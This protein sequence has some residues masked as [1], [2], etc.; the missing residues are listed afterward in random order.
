MLSL[1][2]RLPWPAS[3]E[4]CNRW[5]SS[6]L[7][8][9]C[10]DQYATLQHRCPGCA[11]PMAPGLSLCVRCREGPPRPLDLC[12]ARVPYS[13]PWADTVARLKF[14]GQPAWAAEMARLMLQ[15]P[16]AQ[17]LL[18]QC[19]RVA[20]IPLPLD[21][22]LDRGYNQA[23]ELVRH[24]HRLAGPFDAAH[25]L[26]LREATDHTQHSLPREERLTHARQVFKVNPRH[27]HTVAGQAVLLVDDVMTT[28]ATLNSAAALLRQAGARAVYGWV[29]ARTPAPGM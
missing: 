21:R 6:A 7:C 26:L 29:F 18:G 28:G 16:G 11:L 2:A 5:P 8:S 12:L 22:L 25:D 13:Y 14:Q 24:V 20:P 9:H 23:W 19:D 15:D 10:L 4:V 27:A 1:L 3:C 17:V